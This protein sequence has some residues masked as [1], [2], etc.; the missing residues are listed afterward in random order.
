MT[1]KLQRYK[2]WDLTT[3]VFHWINATSVLSLIIVGVIILNAKLFGIE[4]EA[5][6]LL[7]TVHVYIGYVFVINLL[8]RMFWAFFG[9][10]HARWRQILPTGKNYFHSLKTY[11]AN[12]FT[13][14]RQQYL[15]HNPIAR[16][17]ISLF[18]ILLT[19]QAITGLV[20]AGTDLYYPPFGGYFSEW[21]TGGDPE[22]LKQLR[23]GD[24]SQVVESAYAEM[25]SFRKPFISFHVYGFY[26]L[27]ILILIHIIGVIVTEVRE[28]NGL[29]SAMITGEKVLDDLPQDKN[30][31][32]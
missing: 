11:A 16:L 10:Y 30:D 8:W 24:K 6:V 4:G 27:S 7:K 22:R 21:V 25:R 2:V 17:I 26:I 32:N 31:K 5:K 28:K 15:G 1:T 19:M 13:G 14:I 3:R 20:I 18:F 9:N 29:I 12:F 23:P